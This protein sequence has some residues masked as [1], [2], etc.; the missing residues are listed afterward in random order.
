[1]IVGVAIGSGYDNTT[2]INAVHDNL[3]GKIRAIQGAET[4][5][6]GGHAMH[7]CPPKDML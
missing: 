4:H 2:K 1:M 5:G 3:T 6:K 7:A